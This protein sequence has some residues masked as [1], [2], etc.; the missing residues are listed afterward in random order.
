MI[1]KVFS[2]TLSLLFIHLLYLQP[3]IFAQ[4]R[5]P[6]ISQKQWVDSVYESMST[7]QRIGQLFMVAAYSNKSAGYN[8]TLKEFIQTHQPGGILFM[9][10][11]PV[12]QAQLTNTFQSASPLPLM[13]GMDLEWGLSMRLDSTIQFPKQM[14]LG[15]LTNDSLIYAMGADIA[16]QMNALGVHI[17]FAPVADINYR[18]DNPVIGVRSFGENKELVARKSVAY[19]SGLQDHGVMAVAKHFPGHGDTNVDSH[20]ALPVLPFSK[21]RLD[22]LESYPFKQ[23]IAKNIGGIMTGHLFVPALESQDNLPAS[24]SSK[25]TRDYLREEYKFD[26][27]VF[28]DAL[29]MKAVTDTFSEGEA[30]LAAFLAGADVLLFP[31]NMPASV[32][33]IAEEVKKKKSSERELERSVKRILQTKYALGLTKKPQINTDNLH[34]RL[35]TSESYMLALELY[36]QSV[37]VVRNSADLLPVKLLEDKKFA[38]LVLGNGDPFQHYL[39]EYAGFTQFDEST[40][41]E[42]LEKQLS[43]FDVVIVGMMEEK[44]LADDKLMKILEKTADKTKVI[45]ALFASP[46]ALAKLEDF[47]TILSVYSQDPRAQL[48]M[49]EVIFGAIPATGRLPV[50]AS[51]KFRAGTGI[52]VTP[53]KRLAHHVPEAAGMDSRTL[54]KID[55]LVKEAIDDLATP[56]CQVLVAKDG[57]IIFDKSYGYY[58]YDSIKPV[59]D[60]TIYDLAS[61][62]KVLST[63]QSIMFLEERGIIDLDKKISAYLPELKGTNKE[64]MIIRDILTH[65]AGLWPYVPFW[66]QT[67]DKKYNYLPE[68]YSS[69]QNP[70]YTMKVRDNLFANPV[71]KDSIWQWVITSKLRKKEPGKHFDYKYS[72]IGYYMMQRLVQSKTNQDLAAFMQQNFYDPLGMSSTSYNPLEHFSAIRIAPT[73]NDNIFRKALV[74]GMVHDQGA[75]LYGGVAGH[76]GLFSTAGDIAKISQMLL[77]NGEYGGIRYFRKETIQ[78]FT[79][80][81]YDSNRRGL[82]W[83]KPQQGDWSGPTTERASKDTYGHT[84]F[85]GTAVWIDPEFNLIYVFLSNRIYPDASNNKLLKANTRS[86]IQ[87]VI[88]DS[89]YKYRSTRFI[90]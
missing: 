32:K 65:Q 70:E 80:Q 52:D 8:Q 64:N 43:A 36:K 33:L 82:G 84:G 11:G 31:E 39:Q 3:G 86:R 40:S 75:A 14:V 77:Q 54:D 26:G 24:L 15:A 5:I 58:T 35:N 76:A 46:Y 20:K 67:M 42:M 79:A 13:I 1:K 27:L 71:V 88:Y 9:Q 17:S 59:T 18:P 89:I 6:D 48:A 83:D 74:A 7:E 69:S 68:Y 62:T 4:D 41:M 10:G 25:V 78:K 56:G 37:T 12:R 81:Q 73:E 29:N 44:Y 50:T 90:N 38:S 87:E 51:D 66:A 49:A 55:L 16:R 2:A 22:T 21:E 47:N 63:V 34:L 57:K 23:L 85:T 28:T 53:L 72:D 60:R 30:A 19:A 45:I 61:L